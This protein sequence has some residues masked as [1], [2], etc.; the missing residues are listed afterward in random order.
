MLGVSLT[1]ILKEVQP[2][3]VSSHMHYCWVYRGRTIIRVNDHTA[4]GRWTIAPLGSGINQIPNIEDFS[5]PREPA[6][7]EGYAFF[8]MPKL[9]ASWKELLEILQE[10]G[11]DARGCTT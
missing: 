11:L 4:K 7:A 5:I 6:L 10:R 8:E 2:K 1:D 9:A 3:G